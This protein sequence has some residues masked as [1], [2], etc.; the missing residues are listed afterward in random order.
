MKSVF[1]YDAYRAFLSSR[2]PT[3]GNERGRRQALADLLG[4]QTS[5]ISQVVTERVHMSEEML[6]ATAEFLRLS[7]TEI[8]FLLLLHRFERASSKHLREFYEKRVERF[9]RQHSKVEKELAK[10]DNL[11]QDEQAKYYSSWLYAA[12]HIATTL[13]ADV[14]FEFLVKLLVVD[15][16]ELARALEFLTATGLIV[17]NGV[18]YK[19]GKRRVHLQRTSALAVTSHAA[20]RNESIRHIQKG[21]AHN[22]HYSAV[23]SLSKKDFGR[24]RK[25][26]EEQIL[27]VETVI[28][29]SKEEELCAINIDFFA[30][31][32]K[33]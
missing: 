13:A 33:P 11:N 12:A 28:A 23:Y 9:R 31:E 8:E 25:M 6:L 22:L 3:K 19:A 29:P 20:W 16:T 15:E 24:I 10:E 1:E 30:Y 27:E 18:N 32:P 26:L 21:D 4:C 7:E 14:T 2:F 5:F 17:K